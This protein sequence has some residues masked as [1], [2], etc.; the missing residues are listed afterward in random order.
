M[1]LEWKDFLEIN[2]TTIVMCGVKISDVNQ[3]L[4]QIQN[5]MTLMCKSHGIKISF[6]NPIYV[7]CIKII[8]DI[9]P[10][11]CIYMLG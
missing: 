3:T 5:F 1:A 9:D 4:T 6:I 11:L 7:C 8:P 2:S 10:V